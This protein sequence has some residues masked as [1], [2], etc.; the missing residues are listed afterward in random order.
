M[1]LL[2]ENGDTI[3]LEDGTPFSNDLTIPA[4]VIVG[5]LGEGALLPVVQNGITVAVSVGA[6]RAFL[7]SQTIQS[8]LFE[9]LQVFYK[10]KFK[11]KGYIEIKS[12]A[13]IWIEIL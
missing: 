2:T 12:K 9:N 13:R 10:S 3:V 11:P 4:L 8:V 6:L 5:N 7:N 1:A